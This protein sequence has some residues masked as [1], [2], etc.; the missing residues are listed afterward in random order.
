VYFTLL[1]S[2]ADSRCVIRSIVTSYIVTDGK[3][4]PSRV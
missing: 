3:W 4:L 1:E 2:C